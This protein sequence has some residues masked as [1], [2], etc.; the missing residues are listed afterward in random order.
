[1]TGEGGMNQIFMLKREEKEDEDE[2]EIG[3][4]SFEI[5]HYV[6]DINNCSHVPRLYNALLS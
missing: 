6:L 2:R 4:S 5:K 3:A 1:M